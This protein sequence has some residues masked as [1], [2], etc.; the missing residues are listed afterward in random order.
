MINKKA[1]R[2]KSRKYRSELTAKQAELFSSRI[3]DTFV[4]MEVFKDA[5]TIYV[6]KSVNNE[7]NVDYI[8]NKA[9]ETGKTVA[10]PR[11]N[12]KDMLFYKITDNSELIRGYMGIPE[13]VDNPNNLID[14]NIN[15]VI[16][17]PGLAFDENCQRTGYG[18]G[19]YD[20]FLVKH[21]GL[22]KVGVA[23]DAQIYNELE[24][25]EHDINV[26]MI[27][28]ENRVLHRFVVL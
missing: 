15:G 25:D 14:E 17:V 10:I 6:Y 7:V 19:F 20:R 23:Y 9:Y 28:T 2:D 11:V 16:I 3:C 18:G 26:D 21:P 13:P 24:T 22:V 5:D 1:A 8:I 12:G 4:S 27:I